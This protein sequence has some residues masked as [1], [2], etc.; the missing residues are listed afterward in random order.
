MTFNKSVKNQSFKIR[1]SVLHNLHDQVVIIS[2]YTCIGVCCWIPDTTRCPLLIP[3]RT[4]GRIEKC[5]DYEANIPTLP[6][7]SCQGDAGATG[8]SGLRGHPGIGIIGPKVRE[9]HTV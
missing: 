3:D 7:S 2:S 8:V 6:S 9:T 5:M 1:D 4:C